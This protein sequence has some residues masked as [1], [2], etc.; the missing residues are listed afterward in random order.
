V[1]GDRRFAIATAMTSR[2]IAGPL[3]DVLTWARA[4]DDPAVFHERFT[5]KGVA[6]PEMSLFA[7]TV[8]G[9]LESHGVDAADHAVWTLLRR[10]GIMVFDFTS[11]DS[12]TVQLAR[13]QCARALPDGDADRAGA[14]WS[15]LIE[16]ALRCAAAGGEIDRDTLLSELAVRGFK[17][18]G[19]PRNSAARRRLAEE[20]GLAIAAIDDSIGG[21]VL[22]RP[23]RLEEIHAGL[24]AARYLEVRGAGGVGKSGLLKHL[25]GTVGAEGTLIVLSPNRIPPRGWPTFRD[26]I[27]YDGSAADLIGEVA[28]GGGGLLLIDNI[29]GFS[30]EERVTVVD[31]VNEASKGRGLS[32]VVTCRP[33]FGSDD[34]P[35]WLP[36]AALDRLDRARPVVL[37][38]LTDSER[39]DL[40]RAAPSLSTLLGQHHPARAIVGN[41]YRLKRLAALGAEDAVR[42]EVELAQ[43]WWRQADGRPE[44]RRHR[45]FALETLAEQVV[46]GA[47]RH[48]IASVDGGAVDSLVAS[49]TLL[50]LDS[51]HVVFRHDVLRDWAA[52]NWLA[53]DPK[54]LQAL[55]L[56]RPAPPRLVRGLELLSRQ[57]LAAKADDA[58][59][60]SLL[61]QVSTPGMHGSWRRAVLLAIVRADDAVEQLT[62]LRPRLLADDGA[63]LVELIRLVVAVEVQPAEGF[64]T[65]LGLDITQIPEGMTVPHGPAWQALI[66]VVPGCFDALPAKATPAVVDLYRRWLMAVG[67]MLK[68]SHTLVRQVYDWMT[69]LGPVD[70]S[71][72]RG[73][74][75]W[76]TALE[77]HDLEA[78]E[79]NL[80]STFVAYAALTPDLAKQYIADLRAAG[81]YSNGVKAA[82]GFSGGLPQAAPSEYADLFL[83]ALLE[84]LGPRSPRGRGRE[85]PFSYLDHD[86]IPE[87]PG[88]GPFFALFRASPRVALDLVRALV[89]QEI[90]WR[91]DGAAPEVDFTTGVGDRK[92]RFS[93][94]WSYEFAR[95]GARGHATRCALMA[96]EAWGHGRIDA[97]ETIEAVI[98]DIWGADGDRP[99][100]FAL[101]AVDLALS[102]SDAT[103]A[104]VLVD[105]MASPELLALDLRRQGSERM[106]SF[107]PE[108]FDFAWLRKKE[109]GQGGFTAK[110]LAERSSRSITLH[111]LVPQFVFSDAE[112][113][114]LSPHYDQEIVRLGAPG[115]YA[116]FTDT[117]FMAAHVRS[118]LDRS[119]WKPMNDGSGR[120]AFEAPA[121][122][123]QHLARLQDHFPGDDF[124]LALI[125]S[126]VLDQP[127]PQPDAVVRAALQ[128]LR[129]PQSNAAESA[130]DG[131]RQARAQAAYLVSRDA[132][133]DLWVEVG[134][135]VT[136]ALVA[137]REGDDDHFRGAFSLLQYNP[138]GLAFIGLAQAFHRNPDRPGA[139]RLLGV[140]S[141]GGLAAGQAF[142]HA[143]DL[144]APS[145]PRLPLSLLRCA[146]V[147][148][149]C[150]RRPHWD[151]DESDLAEITERIARDRTTAVDS[152]L[153]WLFDG[154]AEPAWPEAVER[155]PRPR[156]KSRISLRRPADVEPPP[157]GES[158]HDTAPLAVVREDPVYEYFHHQ[159]A[160][161]WLSGTLRL[162]D[163]HWI[164]GFVA[165]G[166]NWTLVL[167]GLGLENFDELSRD[168]DAWNG[169][170]FAAL[171]RAAAQ[172]SPELFKARVAT[173]FSRLP[174]RSILKVAPHLL[175]GLDMAVF[176]RHSMTAE[177][178][179]RI[180]GD[181][182][183][184][185]MTTR[186]WR[187]MIG[188][189]S[190]SI[191][192]TLG[193]AA[194]SLFFADHVFG[195]GVSTNLFAPA[196]ERLDPYLPQTEKQVSNCPSYYV[197]MAVLSLVEVAPRLAFLP[198]LLTAGET[199]LEAFPTNTV[200]WVDNAIGRRLCKLYGALLSESPA[201]FTTATTERLRLETVLA[202]L[203]ALGV[204]DASRIE[205]LLCG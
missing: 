150:V 102:H 176:N 167:N 97:G 172:W 142:A 139:E 161:A 111:Q 60:A 168:P 160:A 83:H 18:D 197:A 137:E 157:P 178:A 79:V 50:E 183:D 23:E 204:A 151:E 199:W 105:L 30:L 127:S 72:I 3:Q 113:T 155:K 24:N 5:R 36:Q 55:G 196:L 35:N 198:L 54:R 27:G 165:N 38:D 29:E 43:H 119:N 192:I 106:S 101:L 144:I 99:A 34:Q 129:K 56:A 173:P 162:S 141:G 95:H 128:R 9:H 59:W 37:G 163:D 120:L 11:P 159:A 93:A 47:E 32:V 203:V 170:F 190:T 45:S 52:F 41:L 84:P 136:A 103:S 15:A 193:P 85:E 75:G 175:H 133:E 114:V 124:Q 63:L 6:G 77:P 64:F 62:R 138:P 200:F 166:L 7:E 171:G 71:F 148:G 143:V 100:P 67:G 191:E 65:A 145:D 12:S 180:R 147:G 140:A 201:A 122:E 116:G 25:A 68:D 57:T 74:D 86:F 123:T 182:A 112:Q 153:A 42:T 202:R 44:G 188:K 164:E 126:G 66:A 21:T 81:S 91:L 13:H 107:M 115:A 92:R 2:K 90:G 88:Q 156:R 76:F 46:G 89:D 61:E 1:A 87:S 20:T 51:R 33:E 78:L 28:L 205:A 154:K 16:V 104:R 134:T 4:V 40:R 73:G 53:E 131:D 177:V 14:L 17:L 118:L 98:R 152:E 94:A 69:R 26:R 146:L 169:A 22:Y 149:R 96:A 186:G 19:H 174:E 121:A 179:A 70:R 31:L 195:Q 158:D 185:V 110:S 8:R 130:L 82:V 181:I 117:A 48:D 135:E 58:A 187:G 132:T 49:E 189:F 109:P 108:L 184:V 10:L 125:L 39:A 80:R 194:A